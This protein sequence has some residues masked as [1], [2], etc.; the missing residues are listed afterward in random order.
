MRKP[1]HFRKTRMTQG[2]AKTG[3]GNRPGV[4]KIRQTVN[5]SLIRR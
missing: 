3:K 1:D 2:F 5:Q 4:W